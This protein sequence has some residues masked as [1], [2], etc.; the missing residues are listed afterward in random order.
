M[1]RSELFM[2]RLKKIFLKYVVPEQPAL[3]LTDGHTSYINLDGIDLFCE[4]NIILFF[5]ICKVLL[6][7]LLAVYSI[8]HAFNEKH[9]MWN[10]YPV[11]RTIAWYPIS[12]Y[13]VTWFL[14]RMPR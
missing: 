2:A 12:S 6:N 7:A 14:T 10:K 4:N 13:I 5:W 1:D 8:I 3:F 9:C 11:I